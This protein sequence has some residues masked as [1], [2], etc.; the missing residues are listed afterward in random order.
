MNLEEM[1]NTYRTLRKSA[2]RGSGA[3]LAYNKVLIC[4]DNA[5]DETEAAEYLSEEIENCTDPFRKRVYQK[6]LSDLD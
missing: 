3:E 1:R 2:H 6:A 5:H 4:L